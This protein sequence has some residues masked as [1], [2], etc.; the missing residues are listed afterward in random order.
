MTSLAGAPGEEDAELVGSA[1]PSEAS[2]VLI[3]KR[4]DGPDPLSTLRPATVPGFSKLILEYDG[5]FGAAALLGTRAGGGLFVVA[6]DFLPEDELVAAAAAHYEGFFG[7]VC[8]AP[9][10]WQALPAAPSAGHTLV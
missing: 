5:V 4:L 9:F 6:A 3:L 1:A 8:H 7:P 2:T 10:S